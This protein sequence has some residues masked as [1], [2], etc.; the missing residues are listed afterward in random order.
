MPRRITIQPHLSVAELESRY[1]HSKDPVER[2]H[3]QIIWL[4]AKGFPTEQ[5]AEV[6]G[7]CR[8]WIRQVARRYNQEGGAGVGDRRHDNPGAERLLSPQQETE[9]WKA[10]QGP[11]PTGRLWNSRTVADWISERIAR[12][13]AVQ[14]GWDYLQQMKARLAAEGTLSG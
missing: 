14:R 13:V 3:Y 7:Y 6:T 2:T 11:P 8:E 12:P 10:L 5:V 1:R 9:L 4:L